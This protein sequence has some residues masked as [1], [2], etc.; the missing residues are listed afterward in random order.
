MALTLFV[1]IRITVRDNLRDY[2]SAA[3]NGPISSR[4]VFSTGLSVFYAFLT[5]PVLYALRSKAE[6]TAISLAGTMLAWIGASLEAV[7]DSHKLALSFS[8]KNENKNEFRGPTT[9]TYRICR[10]FFGGVSSFGRSI[11]AWLSSIIGLLVVNVAIAKSTEGIE[12]RHSER[13]TGQKR[14]D[15]WRKQLS[16]KDDND[17]CKISIFDYADYK[18]CFVL[19]TDVIIIAFPSIYSTR[20]N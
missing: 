19:L 3:D 2:Q 6:T 16:T 11:P 17:I 18:S 10:I 1:P 14:F 15:D 12:K 4:L 13:Y 9:W 7:A 5:T 20:V 8:Q